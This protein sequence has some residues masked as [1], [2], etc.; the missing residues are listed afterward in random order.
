MFPFPR[1]Q[2]PLVLTSCLFLHI[3][4]SLGQVSS[5][6]PLTQA[7]EKTLPIDAGAAFD[8]AI[9]ERP[10][11]HLLDSAKFLSPEIRERVDKVLSDEARNFA[12]DVYLLTVPSLKKNTLDPFTQLVAASWTKDQFGAVVVFDDGAGLVSIEASE[13]VKGRFPE[14]ELSSLLREAMSDKKLPKRSLEGLEHTT[15][16]VTAVL[17]DL[18]ARVNREARNARITQLALA[19]LVLF[20][21]A[22]GVFE[23]YRRRPGP[24]LESKP[25]ETTVEP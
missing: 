9:P 19:I 17:H 3:S 20:G 24:G 1:R 25:A 14:Y 15:M 7:A 4:V 2:L 21:L 13:A 8:L 10:A 11:G 16:A 12:V 18:K 22:V 23:Y 5:S 6:N